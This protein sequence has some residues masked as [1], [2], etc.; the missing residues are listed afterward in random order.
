MSGP[1]AA[2]LCGLFTLMLLIYILFALDIFPG[3]MMRHNDGGVH[4]DPESVR[5]F[6]QENIDASNMEAFLSHITSFD[7]VAGTEGDLYMAKWMLDYWGQVGNFDDL[8]LLE[9][10]VYLNYP[11]ERSVTLKKPGLPTWTATLEEDKVYKDRQQSLT[12]HGH[13]RSGEVEG[14]LIYANSG[15]RDDFEYL[16]DQGIVTKGAVAL[17][18][19]GGAQTDRALKIKAAEDAGC[20]GA[21]LYSDPADV[22]PQNP[23][24]PTE[25]M[26]QRGGVSMMS[27]VVGDPLTPGYASTKGAKTVSKD[28]NPGLPNI[29]SLPLAW[30][31]AKALIYALENHGAKVP[32]GWVHGPRDFDLKTWY[33]GNVSSDADKDIPTLALKNLNDENDK[34]QIWNLHA[35]IEGLESPEK[36]IFVGAHR[37]SWCFGSVDPGSGTAVLMEVVRIF[38]ELRKLGWRPLRTIEFVSWD[39]EEYNIVGSTEYVEDNADYLRENSVAYINVDS[40][41]YGPT[42]QA[43]GSPLWQR[44]LMHVLERVDDPS[45][46][47]TLKQ[48][49]DVQGTI[50]E[51]L[52]AGSDYVPFQSLVGTSSI[53]FGFME[54]NGEDSKFYPYHSCHENM[55]WMQQYGDPGFV[56]HKQLAQVWA[57]LILE[58]ADRPLLPFD[59]RIYAE[60]IHEYIAALERYAA[61]SYAAQEKLAHASMSDLMASKNF[62]LD[63][64]KQAADLLTKNAEH[65]HKF[66]EL[67]TAAVLGAGGLEQTNF[68]MQRIDWNQKLAKFES[69]LLDLEGLPGRSQ[70][71]HV[72]FAPELWGGYEAGY[73]PGVRDAVATGDWTIAMNMVGRVAERVKGASEGLV[74]GGG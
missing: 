32:A 60:R 1:T 37:D 4:F 42:F 72:V 64:L 54:A 34:Q 14:H 66:E 2:R 58:I 21:L 67:W 65:F 33:T 18:K 31:D 23:W 45:G 40:G 69:D 49:W 56:R 13:S 73:F 5:A 24:Q 30:R 53:D 17:I 9:Y 12:W 28:Q 16:K 11:G 63:P 57:L 38:G 50:F 7:H 52:G 68:A 48:S 51:G 70:F 25:D 46:S 61:A 74:G 43:Q 36:K 39:A 62:T 47:G 19:Y 55:E 41:V 10:Y 8:A 22:D 29:P 6:I 15:S 44:A 27:Y 71:K 26:L 35:M 20:V 59:L 3:R